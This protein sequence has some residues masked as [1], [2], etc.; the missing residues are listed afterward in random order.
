MSDLLNQAI[1]DAKTLRETA[2]KNA[3]TL[4][5]EKYS[6]QIKEA[7]ESMLEQDDEMSP[8]DDLEGDMGSDL[9]GDLGGLEGGMG[10]PPSQV[11]SNVPM[12]AVN[13]EKLCQC[14]EEDEEIEINFGELEQQMMKEPESNTP[15]DMGAVP[16]DQQMS[17]GDETEDE[18][19]LKE[20]DLNTILESLNKEWLSPEQDDQTGPVEQ[21]DMKKL[22]AAYR[23]GQNVKLT[24]LYK[25][26]V[27]GEN[28]KELV[29]KITNVD[30]TNPNT[31]VYF[32]NGKKISLNDISDVEVEGT[33]QEDKGLASDVSPGKIRTIRDD[34]HKNDISKEELSSKYNLPRSAIDRIIGIDP[35]KLKEDLKVDV[36][37]VKSGWK[38]VSGSK[39]EMNMD[40]A[41]AKTQDSKQKEEISK[42]MK[43][44]E[45]A[46]I[47][48]EEMKK[49]INIL[50]K[51]L[52][53]QKELLQK[54]YK[55]MN[56]LSLTNSKL[57]YSNRVYKD[58]SLN[59][60]QKNKIVESL[61]KVNTIDNVK[62]IYE[63]LTT[64][65]V[66]SKTP[67]ESLS[68]TLHKPSGLMFTNRNLTRGEQSSEKSEVV[69]R[70]QVLAGI[71][72][73]QKEK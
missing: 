48:L 31:P 36:N 24:V 30:Y 17:T 53:E 58:N 3:E 34:Y 10:Q 44:K 55:V 70:M 49:S 68:E 62:V 4:I 72:N 23:D 56:E 5:L 66:S 13:G 46:T 8:E 12:A 15:T 9:S 59:E 19:Q 25:D 65:G 27:H 16:S 71:K 28:T 57:M 52:N 14:P 61:S 39:S 43:A 22:E 47:K 60:R 7:I 1:I 29:G 35:E 45:E 11:A 69:S 41:L 64:V 42:L 2:M 73:K 67:K 51:Q 21:L 6:D 54:S 33:L 40:M 38:D 20:E 63:S 37:P 50:Q 26:P 18:Y 32:V